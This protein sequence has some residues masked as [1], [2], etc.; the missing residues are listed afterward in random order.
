MYSRKHS[1]K[2]VHHYFSGRQPSSDYA[3]TVPLFY[4]T[5]SEFG[6]FGSRC[7]SECA[8]TYST[9]QISA[10]PQATIAH[11][12]PNKSQQST[13]GTAASPRRT[14]DQ[15]RI[16]PPILKNSRTGSDDPPK[17]AKI[18][19]P[20]TKIRKSTGTC[21]R[22]DSE[23]SAGALSSPSGPMEKGSKNVGKKRTSFAGAAATRKTRPGAT[24]KRSSQSSASSEQRKGSQPSPSP[25]LQPGK[26]TP[27]SA[28]GLPRLSKSDLSTAPSPAPLPF[29]SSSLHITNCT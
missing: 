27:K 29:R 3:C 11:I 14:S 24:R 1:C 23:E 10:V 5:Y 22:R 20:S 17:S 16:L 2:V 15:S 13:L 12:S 9:F 8:L 6:M 18:S 26:T 25:R 4:Y 7:P 28:M 21:A 19:L